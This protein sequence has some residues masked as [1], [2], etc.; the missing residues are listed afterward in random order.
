MKH[1]SLDRMV[2]HGTELLAAGSDYADI[3]LHEERYN[4]G[5][6]S[7]EELHWLVYARVLSSHPLTWQVSLEFLTILR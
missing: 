3:Q 4:L 1:E 7:I 2:A 5:S 6:I